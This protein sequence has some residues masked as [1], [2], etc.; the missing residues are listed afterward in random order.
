[1][2]IAVRYCHNLNYSIRRWT[3]GWRSGDDLCVV[4]ALVVP[5]GTTPEEAAGRAFAHFQR[6]DGR[7]HVDL[8]RTEAPSM[9]I[10]DVVLVHE[11]G[12]HPEHALAVRPVGFERID[13]DSVRLVSRG[14]LTVRGL[15]EERG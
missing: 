11:H 14:K 4:T 2:S 5:S 6:I 10:G 3:A 1:V 9:S 15:V 12:Y 8:D 7:D 13:V